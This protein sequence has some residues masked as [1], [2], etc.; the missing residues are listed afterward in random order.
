MTTIN[1]VP[2]KSRLGAGRNNLALRVSSADCFEDGG[3]LLLDRS[4]FLQ[5]VV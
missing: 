1:K 3:V 4:L 2:L 5:G